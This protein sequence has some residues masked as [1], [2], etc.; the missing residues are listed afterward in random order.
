MEHCYLA[1]YNNA[2]VMQSLKNI[3]TALVMIKTRLVLSIL[4]IK[5]VYT[6]NFSGIFLIMQ[7]NNKVM[8]LLCE[9]NHQHK[10]CDH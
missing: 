4:S 8:T 5:G 9:P 3:H 6:M 1:H 2:I 7:L 10:C